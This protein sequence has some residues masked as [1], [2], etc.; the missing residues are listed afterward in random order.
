MIRRV[1]GAARTGAAGFT[2]IEILVAMFILAIMSGLA[3]G[4]YRAAR[5]SAERTEQSLKRTRQI[6][7]GMRMLVQDFAQIVPRPIRD[8]LGQSRLPCLIGGTG[9]TD[10]A[11]LTRGG[12]SNTAGLQRSTLQRV[13][14]QLDGTVL[15]RSY[16]TVLDPTTN[17]QPVVQRLLTGVTGVQIEYLDMN[18]NWVTQWPPA[19]LPPAEQLTARP[20]AVEIIV[21]FKDWGRVRRLVEVGG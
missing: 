2:L 16:Y 20:A 21:V 12:W 10:L 11:D 7:F 15:D 9:T 8:P 19:A 14:Y 17:D 18:Q 6:E 4:T 13:G 1:R 5:I 3:Y